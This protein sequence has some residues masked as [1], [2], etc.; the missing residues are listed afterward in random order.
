MEQLEEEKD[1]ILVVEDSEYLNNYITQHLIKADYDV[2]QCYDAK[3]AYTA[4]SQCFVS[5]VILD[6][7]LGDDNGM[8]IL[9]TIRKQNKILPVMIVSS[10][11]DDRTK[12]EGLKL[13]CDDY[14]TKP[15]YID[16]LLL[17][18]KRMLLKFGMMNF[19]KQKIN[20]MYQYGIFEIDVENFTVKKQNQ[21]IPM[22]KKQFD[23][24]LYFIQHPNMILTFKSI[25]E[26]VWN[27]PT[28]DEK[29]LESNI[30]VN[31]RSLRLLIEDNIEKPK[32][33]ISVSKIGYIFTC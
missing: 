13:G 25:Y 14:I 19:E 4:L 28:P 9:Q 17:R 23:L 20:Q 3:S 33:I 15:F 12:I 8:D 7:N 18:I 27:E 1:L 21:I 32:Y 31:I 2:I 5:L 30:Y 10:I 29:T 24:M 22:R 16:E 6:L 26:N 11:H